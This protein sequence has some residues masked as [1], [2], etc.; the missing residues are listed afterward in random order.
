MTPGF[1]IVSGAHSAS[2]AAAL[3]PHDIDPQVT[4]N[5]GRELHASASPQAPGYIGDRQ[6]HQR[7][8]HGRRVEDIGV[9]QHRVLAH[10]EP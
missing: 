9:S 10:F 2:K 5:L 4:Y 7:V 3:R 1:S 8:P 6:L